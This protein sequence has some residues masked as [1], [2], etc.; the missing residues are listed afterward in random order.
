VKVFELLVCQALW[1]AK[2]D[3]G[4]TLD[5]LSLSTGLSQ[6]YLSR[7]FNGKQIPSLKAVSAIALAIDPETPYAALSMLNAYLENMT[8]E[9]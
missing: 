9:A 1:K 5:W 3:Y 4:V 6:G 8:D 7:V 2:E